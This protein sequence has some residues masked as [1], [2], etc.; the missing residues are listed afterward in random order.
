[1]T[2]WLG[3]IEGDGR[4]NFG[5]Y[6]AANIRDY[7]KKHAGTPIRLETAVNPVSSEMRG[8]YFGALMPFLRT[9]VPEWNSLSN[10][11]LH[12]VLKTAFNYFEAYNPLS[13]RRENFGQSIMSGDRQNKKA[14]EY[15]MR[16]GDWVTTNYQQSMPDPEIYKKFR[17]S[18]PTLDE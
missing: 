6:N 3:K 7:G 18:A 4:L 17:D 9:L 10:D 14:M 13:G 16:I 11:E 5:E 12:E 2:V 8:Y 1:M 15:I